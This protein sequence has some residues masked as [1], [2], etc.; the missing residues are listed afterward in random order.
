MKNVYGFAGCN[1]LMGMYEVNA[2]RIKFSNMA[3]TKMMCLEIQTEDSM[4]EMMQKSETYRIE[5]EI[6]TLFDG[7]QNAL[8]RLKIVT[9]D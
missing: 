9:F 7:T 2:N 6:V 1:R 4:F 5:N 3:S 8:G